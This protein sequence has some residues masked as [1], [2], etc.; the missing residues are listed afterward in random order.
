MPNAKRGL[1]WRGKFQLL[2]ILSLRCCCVE[3]EV[4]RLRQPY[5]RVCD[6]RHI[7]IVVNR[8]ISH[9]R[10]WN[11]GYGPICRHLL[12]SCTLIGR[13][14]LVQSHRKHG[15]CPSGEEKKARKGR[16]YKLLMHHSTA[17]SL[18]T[19]S[20]ARRYK[21]FSVEVIKPMKPRSSGLMIMG[22]IACM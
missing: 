17:F 8:P 19:V 2:P 21:L 18:H 20:Y 22:I 10:D 3:R 7:K 11:L 13:K 9:S 5:R 16:P 6:K 1:E 12:L 4:G 15:Q 14:I